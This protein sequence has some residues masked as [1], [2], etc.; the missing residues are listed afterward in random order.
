MDSTYVFKVDGSYDLPWKFSSSINFQH[1]TGFP[2]QP[3]E[4]F[5]GTTSAG[6]SKGLNQGFVSVI[7]QPAGIVRYPSVNLRNVRLSREFVMGD[8]LHVQPLI[9]LF[10]L[11]NGQTVVSENTVCCSAYLKPSNT[12]NPFIA[13]FGLRVNF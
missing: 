7:L 12:I 1:Y 11:T 3:T 6:A 4:V 9:D 13:R 8:K 10:N 5:G 2:V